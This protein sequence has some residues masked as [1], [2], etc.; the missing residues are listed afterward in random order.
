M[1]QDNAGGEGN[2]IKQKLV[3]TSSTIMKR[4]VQNSKLC[5]L[6]KS[7]D[8]GILVKI[9]QVSIWKQLG[10]SP[11]ATVKVTVLPSQ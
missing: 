7:E 1:I 9:K 11:M 4:L 6:L 5:I 2:V 3:E 8:P 10:G